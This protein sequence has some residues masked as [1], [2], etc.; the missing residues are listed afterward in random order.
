MRGRPLGTEGNLDQHTRRVLSAR[1]ND[2]LG[3]PQIRRLKSLS[4]SRSQRAAARRIRGVALARA[5]A[6]RCKGGM[7]RGSIMG[8]APGNGAISRL[9]Y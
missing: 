2:F 5:S 3:S 6:T 9:G 1:T 7:A 8:A 4:L